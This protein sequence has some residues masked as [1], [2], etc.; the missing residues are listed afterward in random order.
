MEELAWI[1]PPSI[2]VDAYQR[3]A[4]ISVDHSVR[5]ED[6]NDFEDK[7]ASEVLCHGVVGYE[8]LDHPLNHVLRV[9]L[10]RVNSRAKE[11]V[12]F[13]IWQELFF[14]SSFAYRLFFFLN[15]LRELVD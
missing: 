10:S 13:K 5:I 9:C 14:R 11:Y 6:G 15:P 12:F 7:S 2:E 3:G 1:F 4:V 8:K